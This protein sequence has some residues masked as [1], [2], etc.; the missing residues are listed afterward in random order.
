METTITLNFPNKEMLTIEHCRLDVNRGLK[1]LSINVTNQNNDFSLN[2]IF[3][4]IVENIG[5]DETFTVTVASENGQAV[6]QNITANYHLTAHA[7]ILSFFQK[8]EITKQ[9]EQ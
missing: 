8:Q 5:N 9:D 7:E 6:F 2:A 3:N 4:R 1:N